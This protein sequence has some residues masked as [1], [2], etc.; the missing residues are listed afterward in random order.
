[1]KL[2][3]FLFRQLMSFFVL[4]TLITIAILILGS[5]FDPDAELKYDAMASPLIFA[6]LSVLPGMVMYSRR[7]LSVG[8]VIFRKIIQL[9]LIEAE[10]LAIGFSSPLIHTEQA[11]TVAALVCSVIVIF[12]AAHFFSYLSE[13]HTAKQLTSM[14][15]SFQSQNSK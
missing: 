10:V 5:I 13:L 11:G 9:L 4:T 1:M 6:A 12:A 8:Q 7:E 2:K 3:E 14:L 15:T